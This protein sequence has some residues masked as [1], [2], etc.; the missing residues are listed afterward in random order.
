MS[1]HARANAGRS[2]T[3]R[4]FNYTT[5]DNYMA[6]ICI[7]VTADTSSITIATCFKGAITLN[8]HRIFLAISI[9][10]HLDAREITIIP[11]HDILP[12]KNE[13]TVPQ[14]PNTS[15]FKTIIRAKNFSVWKR[16]S[17]IVGDKN[18]DLPFSPINGTIYDI[19]IL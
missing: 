17:S 19:T 14:T 13:G 6:T 2:E 3:T 10:W 18:S 9:I 1:I 4:C 8:C 7:T 15:R 16:D 12:R 5:F 11:L